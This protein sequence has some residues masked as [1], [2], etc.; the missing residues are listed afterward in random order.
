MDIPCPCWRM[1][2]WEMC[3][4]KT[5]LGGYDLRYS[6]REYLALGG[7]YV[8]VSEER[9]ENY[10]LNNVGCG[11][12]PSSCTA[13]IRVIRYMALPCRIGPHDG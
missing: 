9:C 7:I 8:F 4:R 5:L 6:W 3:G 2:S 11:Y 1:L 12:F 13:M 10:G